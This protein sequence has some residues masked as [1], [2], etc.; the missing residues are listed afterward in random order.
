M[1][2]SVLIIGGSSGIGLA[3][4]R[5]FAARGWTVTL[6]ARSETALARAATGLA[7]ARWQQVD[8]ADRESVRRLFTDC[9]PVDVV[10][11]TAMVMAYGRIDELDADVYRTVVRTGVEGSFHVAQAALA[12]FRSRGRG[13]LIM[14]NSLVGHIVSPQ[15]GAY[16][17]A[18]WAQL[19]LIRTLQLELRG[20][21]GISVCSISPGGVNTPIYRQ[22]ANVTG[23][24]PRP[25]MPVD[26]PD[27]VAAAIVHAA[28]RPGRAPKEVSV[29]LAN[30][31]I[32]L[33]FGLLPKLYDVLVGPLLDRLSLLDRGAERTTGNVF[34]PVPG[35]E[36]E[37]DRW[38]RRWSVSDRH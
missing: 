33:G 31:L 37:R 29:G 5:R 35:E 2:G 3:A 30:P 26:Q 20:E 9:G 36:A 27:K 16:A 8:V 28:E 6:A 23:R 13:R 15:L 24:R 12:G 32:R 7:G 11:H 22:A 10:V 17:S 34:A 14:V 19:A 1:T 18:K 38:T 4:A 25:P 21:P